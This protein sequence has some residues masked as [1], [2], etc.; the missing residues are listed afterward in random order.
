[1]TDG[2]YWTGASY[3]LQWECTDEGFVENFFYNSSNRDLFANTSCVDE[4]FYYERTAS[5]LFEFDCSIFG[6]DVLKNNNLL[7]FYNEEN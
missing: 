7:Y 4:L 3:S 5:S 6:L 2:G 1:M